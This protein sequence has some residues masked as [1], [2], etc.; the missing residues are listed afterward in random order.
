MRGLLPELRFSFAC[1][2]R[3]GEGLEFRDDP[4]SEL[5][6]GPEVE[7]KLSEGGGLLFGKIGTLWCACEI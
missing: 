7:V 2:F 4:F 6:K 3:L 5:P 1:L